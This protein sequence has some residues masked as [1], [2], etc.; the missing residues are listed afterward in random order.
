MQIK[1]VLTI[2]FTLVRM[3]TKK[4]NG[5]EDAGKKEYL[6]TLVGAS[7]VQPLWKS[8]QQKAELPYD[9][10][11][12]LLGIYPKDCESVHHGETRAQDGTMREWM[13]LE[14]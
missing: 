11:I 13:E 10:A 7:R 8:S 5:A 4:T 12:L 14:K 6:Y 9:P 1:T 3:V 2:H